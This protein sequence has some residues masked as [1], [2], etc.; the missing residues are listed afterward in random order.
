M[1]AK[2]LGD[3]GIDLSEI[4]IAH[5]PERVLPGN[6]ERAGRKMTGL[7]AVRQKQQPNYSRFL[8]RLCS[9]ESTWDRC[10]NSRNGKLTENSYR[11]PTLPLLMNSLSCVINWYKCMGTNSFSE[12][13][14]ACKYNFN[15]EQGCGHCIAVDPGAALG[16][17]AAP[18]L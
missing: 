4:H 6:Y 18:V 17:S 7:L 15:P 5:C 10:K 9:G 13:T 16:P 3:N 2:L 8:S 14:S 11:D 12:S 1:V